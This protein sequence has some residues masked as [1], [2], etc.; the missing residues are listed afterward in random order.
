MLNQLKK[1]KD[2]ENYL[3]DFT[4]LFKR[5]VDKF[6]NSDKDD[7]EKVLE[8]RKDS[9]SFLDNYRDLPKWDIRTV[10][11]HFLDSLGINLEDESVEK[12]LFYIFSDVVNEEFP[13]TAPLVFKYKDSD[14]VKKHPVIIDFQLIPEIVDHIEKKDDDKRHLITFN[15]FDRDKLLIDGI[16]KYLSTLNFVIINILDRILYENIIPF[17]ELFKKRDEGYQLDRERLLNIVDEIFNSLYKIA[18][19]EGAGDSKIG[20][21]VEDIVE[22]EREW[23]YITD[24][25]NID[26]ESFSGRLAYIRDY[27]TQKNVFETAKKSDLNETEKLENILFL[28]GITNVNPIL[29]IRYFDGD[30]IL[31][32]VFNLLRNAQDDRYLTDN[33]KRAF[34]FF[35]Q[36]LFQYPYLSER[37]L[38]RNI[39]D[40]ALNFLYADDKEFM[41]NYLYFTGR[42]D[43]FLEGFNNIDITP[44]LQL[45]QL[46]AKYF[47]GEFSQEELLS[48]LVLVPLDEAYFIFHLLKKSLDSLP[49]QNKYK[50]IAELYNMKL[51]VEHIIEAIG[52]EGFYTLVGRILGFY[53]YDKTLKNVIT[54][55]Y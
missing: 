50:Y 28:L 31:Y 16:S 7:R 51:P 23:E 10:M 37:Y 17:D 32:T 13:E 24:L 39:L 18:K 33:L 48:W 26:E 36:K 40:K 53:P 42:Y 43:E 4:V 2:I 47:T 35:L 11:Y 29:L 21:L 38:N 45:K 15:L 46:L 8:F 52:E 5:E 54:G 14:L 27:N 9:R 55:I 44:E 12:F 20:K 1:R 25:S 3:D 19:G 34:K 30:D 22:N 41:L 6:L 49:L